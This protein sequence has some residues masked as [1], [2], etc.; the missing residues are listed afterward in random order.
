MRI[1]RGRHDRREQNVRAAE[2]PRPHLALLLAPLDRAHPGGGSAGHGPA[3]DQAEV[4][5]L[6]TSSSRANS[7]YIGSGSPRPMMGI[8]RSRHSPKPSASGTGSGTSLTWAPAPGVSRA[9]NPSSKR[10]DVAGQRQHA[11]ARAEHGRHPEPG[12][13]AVRSGPGVQAEAAR[14]PPLRAGRPGRA[15]RPAGRRQRTCGDAPPR[16]SASVR[17]P[18]RAGGMP[19][20]GHDAPRRLQPEH[21]AAVRWDAD[22]AADVGA[23]LECRKPARDRGGHTA[24]RPARRPR[25]LP[26]VV[27][28]AE[29]V[30]VR[31]QVG[32]D[33]GTLDLPNT[34][35]PAAFSRAPGRV[36]DGTCS[37]SSVASAVVSTPSISMTS[38]IVIGSP[39]SGPASRRARR[40]GRPRPPRRGPAGCPRRR[41]R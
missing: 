8:T 1:R 27:R 25:R 17:L 41:S 6:G 21:P 24:G 16:T 35:A 36:V 12:G 20:A 11:L 37:V 10:A 15:P 26:R 30:V 4:V 28:R 34:I 22:R 14:L 9:A 7:A 31:L 32:P 38:L 33:R 23:E 19:A 39:C 13:A 29:Q 3:V 2:E 18:G 5:T 40:P